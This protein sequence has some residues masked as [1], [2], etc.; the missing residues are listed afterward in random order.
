MGRLRQ[1]FRAHLTLARFRTPT[2]LERLPQAPNPLTFPVEE[3][4]LYESRLS[5]SGSTYVPLAQLPLGAKAE[6]VFEFAPE[7]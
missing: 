3:V 5:S 4:V 6:S 7:L 1:P 2:P